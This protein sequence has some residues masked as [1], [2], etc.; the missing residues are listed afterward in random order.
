MALPK[1]YQG[2]RCSLARSLEVLGERW[3]L[4]IIRDTFHGVRRFSDFADHLGIPRSVLAT[5]LEALVQ[6][7]VIDKTSPTV[8]GYSEYALTAKG[9]GLWPAM[10]VLTVWG[11]EHYA[12]GGAPRV[13]EHADDGGPIDADRRCSSCG[14]RIEPPD[15]LVAPGRG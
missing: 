10:H 9:R 4:L 11:D 5:R 1:H 15:M 13:Y 6:Q 12:D 14:Q 7:G 8:H 2:Q 3:T